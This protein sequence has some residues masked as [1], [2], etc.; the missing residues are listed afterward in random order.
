MLA[1]VKPLLDAPEECGTVACLID[2]NIW[3]AVASV[4]CLGL[5]L[6]LLCLLALESWLDREASA[7]Q[8]RA[9]ELFWATHNPPPAEW[10]GVSRASHDLR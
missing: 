3:L 2:Q 4:A 10:S 5:G 8:A 1:P 7:A 9:A 6:L